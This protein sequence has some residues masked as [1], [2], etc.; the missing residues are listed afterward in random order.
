M[1]V[2][3][4][5]EYRGIGRALPP[6][7]EERGVTIPGDCW[8]DDL[9]RTVTVLSCLEIKSSSESGDEWVRTANFFAVCFIAGRSDMS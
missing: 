9:G 2:T 3:G 1:I 6:L 5:G 7:P 4:C 8:V